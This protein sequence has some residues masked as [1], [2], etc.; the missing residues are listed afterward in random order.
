[1]LKISIPRGDIRN[2]KIAIKDPSGDLTGLT[3]DDIY[4]TVKRGYLN[5]EFKFQ[6]RLSDG[7]ITKNEEGYYLFSIL[8]NDT[9]NLPFGD[10]D[11]DIEIVKDDAIKQTTVGVLTLT[12]EVTYQSNEA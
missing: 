5:Q 1:M 6:K 11:F 3:F 9:N 8:P 12:K 4:F 7:T 2:F 10:Y